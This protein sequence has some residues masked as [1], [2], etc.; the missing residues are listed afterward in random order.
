[1]SRYGDIA[2]RSATLASE[3]PL[4]RAASLGRWWTEA[5]VT[6]LVASAGLLAATGAVLT[7]QLNLR[8]R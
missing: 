5:I 3:P 7:V 2:V 1:M 8:G 4:N 6:L